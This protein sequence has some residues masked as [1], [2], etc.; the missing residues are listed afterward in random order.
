M[1]KPN[2]TPAELARYKVVFAL[3]RLGSALQSDVLAD[4]VVARE[5]GIGISNP[6]HLPDGVTLDRNI[7]FGAFQK[8]TDGEAIPPLKDI[9]GA[10]RSLKLEIQNENGVLSYGSNRIAFPQAGLLSESIAKRRSLLAGI[11]KENTLT[12]R[13]VEQ[14]EPIVG[15]QDYSQADFFAARKILAGAPE[16][17]ATGLQEVARNKGELSKDD[18]LPSELSHWENLTAAHQSSERLADFVCC[19]LAE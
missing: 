2:L 6:V 3:R 13:A 1:S 15:K 4:G 8:A 11:L 16:S 14:L 9:D 5:S 12:R 18:L 10:E 17:F 19:E 7:L